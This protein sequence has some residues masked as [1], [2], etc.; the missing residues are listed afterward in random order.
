MQDFV[1][2]F[3]YIIIR[4]QSHCLSKFGDDDLRLRDLTLTLPFTIHFTTS[5]ISLQFYHYISISTLVSI[6]T[7]IYQDFLN[8]PT[9]G[10]GV[11]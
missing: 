9:F 10:N 6:N 7:I 2:L 8:L 3:G 5:P 1:S 11:C 4:L